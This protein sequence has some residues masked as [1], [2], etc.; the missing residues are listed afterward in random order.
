MSEN[1]E[2]REEEA[3]ENY[4][5]GYYW[6]NEPYSSTQIPGRKSDEDLRNDIIANL[7]AL[8][9]SQVNVTVKNGIATL[10]GTVS[11]YQQRSKAGA[12]AWRTHGILEVLNELD[13]TDPETAG[14]SR[15]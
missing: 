10:T 15:L 9:L 5:S 2:K 12:E 3:S 4:Y 7:S 13:V 8:G 6:G 11:H 14:P 1:K